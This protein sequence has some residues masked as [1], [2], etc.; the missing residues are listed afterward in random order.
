MKAKILSRFHE[1]LGE[2]NL[3][4]YANITSGLNP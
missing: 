2:C 4:E 1:P 3:K